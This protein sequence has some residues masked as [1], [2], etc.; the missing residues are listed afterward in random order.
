MEYFT[1]DE[2]I[3]ALDELQENITHH[4]NWAFNLNRTLIC[5]TPPSDDT[6]REDAH[7]RC[8]LGRWLTGNGKTL[9]GK[10]PNFEFIVQVHEEMHGHARDL[11]KTAIKG[12]KI[13]EQA[14]DQFL[15]S[16]TKLRETIETTRMEL[17]TDI[18]QTDPLTGA[19][20]RQTMQARLQ[21][22][23]TQAVSSEPNTWFMMMDLDHFKKVND[24]YGHSTGDTV[25]AGVATKVRALIRNND[26]FFRY[27]G[28]EFLLC[29]SD[30]DREKI[31]EIA[32]RRSHPNSNFHTRFQ[33]W[34]R[35]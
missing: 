28:E 16:Q 5:G 7:C 6:L 25:L 14:Y 11:A 31:I 21:K 8:K 13:S 24:T 32:D 20:T 26:L 17:Y 12:Q 35:R 30:V 19:E 27:G 29:I 10:H 22:K 23:L 34:E 33:I 18:A 3:H 4:F 15:D 9:F 2:K 1:S